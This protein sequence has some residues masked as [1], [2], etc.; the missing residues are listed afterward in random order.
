[1]PRPISSSKRVLDFARNDNK[2]SCAPGVP[3]VDRC[4]VR[5]RRLRARGFD[6]QP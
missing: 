1:M 6:G 2:L 3:V 5:L 4:F